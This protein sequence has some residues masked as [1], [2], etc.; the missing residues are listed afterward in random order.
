MPA[1]VSAYTALANVTLGSSAASVT[2]S[3]ISQAYKDLVLVV[4]PSASSKVA[5]VNFRFNSDTGSNYSFVYMKGNGTTAGSGAS[6]STEGF[7]DFSDG[8]PAD[9]GNNFV[10]NLFDYSATDRH[11]N[12]LARWNMASDSTGAVAN[13]WASTS[14]VNSIN[15]F[16]SGTTFAAGSTFALYGVSS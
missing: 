9:F 11:K 8:L 2:F 16:I 12:F 5:N 3:S 4:T 13:R 14:A 10:V 6:S 7:L 15:V 1:G